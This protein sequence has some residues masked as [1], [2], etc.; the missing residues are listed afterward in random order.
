MKTPDAFWSMTY[1]ASRRKHHHR[2]ACC[3]RIIRDGETVLMARVV[4]KAT[5]VLHEE[6]AA[7]PYGNGHTFRDGLE[8]WGMHYLAECGWSSA[9]QFIQTAPICQAGGRAA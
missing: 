8:A 5:R 4:G 3:K 1:S 6:C 7:K 9:K 2:C